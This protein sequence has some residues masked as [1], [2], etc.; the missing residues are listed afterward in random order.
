[1]IGEHCPLRLVPDVTFEVSGKE[2]KG[3]G[4]PAV[5]GCSRYHLM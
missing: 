3:E 1:V 5:L 4:Y 2:I